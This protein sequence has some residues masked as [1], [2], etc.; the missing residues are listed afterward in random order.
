MARRE[1]QISA[2]QA[3]HAAP[4]A[5]LP[6]FSPSVANS[7]LVLLSRVR[8]GHQQ[9]GRHLGDGQ[10]GVRGDDAGTRRAWAGGV[11]K[12]LCTRACTGAHACTHTFMQARAWSQ[13]SI[14]TSRHT[15]P[16]PP[17][18]PPTHA[19]LATHPHPPSPHPPPCSPLWRSCLRRWTSRC[20][21]ACCASLWTTTSR[22]T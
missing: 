6:M 19:P 17:T 18:H 9:P 1:G 22:T 5:H 15:L 14:C 12:H 4:R 21:T 11:R 16:S 13:H 8:A 20:S 3:M 7:F 2:A 10:R